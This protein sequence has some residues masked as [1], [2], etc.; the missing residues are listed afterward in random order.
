MFIAHND[1]MRSTARLLNG[2]N[3]IT[4]ITSD[5][6]A[7]GMER[8]HEKGFPFEIGACKI[9]YRQI[10]Q[11]IWSEENLVLSWKWKILSNLADAFEGFT[12]PI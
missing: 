1:K 2:A 11:I 7:Y 10:L 8:V 3:Q 4:A 6:Y 12:F 5:N 9:I